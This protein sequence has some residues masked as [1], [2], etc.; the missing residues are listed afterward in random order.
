MRKKYCTRLN[1]TVFAKTCMDCG[2]LTPTKQPIKKAGY[3]TG[4]WEC[5]YLFEKVVFKGPDKWRKRFGLVLE[6]PVGTMI[7]YQYREDEITT[8]SGN[9]GRV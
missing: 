2:K 6:P 1:K 7:K 4:G 5:D 3:E 8:Y 9:S